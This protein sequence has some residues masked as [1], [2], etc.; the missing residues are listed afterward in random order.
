[1]STL[2]PV[3][4]EK[5]YAQYPR[6]YLVEYPV[7]GRTKRP[8]AKGSC[9]TLHSA[10]K[11][12]SN[13]IELGYCAIARIFDRKIGQYVFTYKGVNY[14]TKEGERQEIVRFEGFVR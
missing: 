9:A 14:T 11:H 2:F 8:D 4:T 12:A 3:P 13:S 1:M 5:R 7:D 6:R 10:R